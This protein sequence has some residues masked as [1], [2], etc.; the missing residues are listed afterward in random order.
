MSTLSSKPWI[1][2][3]MGAA[4]AAAALGACASPATPTRQRVQAALITSGIPPAEAR[5]ATKQ[6]FTV[7]KGGQLRNLAEHGSGAL[8]AKTSTALSTALGTCQSAAPTT[9]APPPTVP[10]TATTAPQSAPATSK[11]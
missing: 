6:L 2:L 11:P 3:G 4:I 9:G 8:E 5:C 1:T 10:P 7:L